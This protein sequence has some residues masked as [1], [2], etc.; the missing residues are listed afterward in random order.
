MDGH[1]S[2]GLAHAVVVGGTT[3]GDLQRTELRNEPSNGSSSWKRP[4]AYS[5]ISATLEIGLVIE[6]MR[7]IVSICIGA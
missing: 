5:I 2:L 6:Y 3:I 1:L 7:T 4:S